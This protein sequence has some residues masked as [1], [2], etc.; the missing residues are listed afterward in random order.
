M[1]ALIGLGL[2][3][4][5][6]H[7]EEGEVSTIFHVYVD[8]EHVGTV[9][10]KEVVEKYVGNQV[11]QKQ[12]NYEDY[13]FTVGENLSFV[14]EKTFQ[15]DYSN[16]KVM[17]ALKEDISIKANAYKLEIGGE[18]AGY[19]KNKETAEQ[20]VASYKEKFV[21]HEVLKKLDQTK[22]DRD[23][24]DLSLNDSIILDV[25]LSEKV[26]ISKEK[27]KVKKVLNVEEG[28]KLLEEGTLNDKVHT[29]A[30]GEVLSEIAAKY[31][32]ET[33]KL[34]EL[35]PSLTEE[36]VLQI[37]QEINV[38]EHKPFMHVL[39]HSKKLVEEQ[40]DYKKEIVKSDSLFKGDTEVKQEGQT[41]KKEVLYSI[42]KQ[43][44]VEV[45]KEK[46]EEQVTKKPVKE[47]IIKGTKVIES[48]GT[49][50][51]Q[52]PAVGGSIT[53]HMGNRWGSLHKGMDIAGVSNRSILAADNGVVVSAGY[54]S[55][56][57]GN[58]VIINHK[59]GYKTIYAH[60]NSINVS[61]GETVS[62]GSKIGVMGTTG[63]STGVHLHFE[64]YKNGS[65]QNPSKFF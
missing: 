26:S 45:N 12:K 28:R 29:V 14:P 55:G 18:I 51:F 33:D 39:V 31:D 24:P 49:G 8:G 35:N 47:I 2:T 62:K 65:L 46:L 43:N 37:G 40:I 64:V 36:T 17:E 38:T 42:E 41:G 53:S 52:W 16:K 48:R 21:D 7:A 61:T 59:N 5:V 15:S 9:S 58:K 63:D 60:L 4:N 44:G 19:F 11:K 23:E 57:Y 54:D 25:S 6:V 27:V 30:E 22:D 13:S 1:I 20:T 32:L 50:S 56:G 3:F 34:L 10:D